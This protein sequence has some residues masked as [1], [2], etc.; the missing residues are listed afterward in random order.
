MEPAAR[1]K[2]MTHAALPRSKAF[3]LR[4]EVQARA[5]DERQRG[6]ID[7]RVRQRSTSVSLL[8]DTK[9][10]HT[11]YGFHVTVHLLKTRRGRPM[12]MYRGYT[13]TQ[14]A[15]LRSGYRRW[16]CSSQRHK[17]CK[18]VVWTTH[19]TMQLHKGCGVHTHGPPSFHVT[20]DVRL[21]ESRQG[22]PMVLY[23]GYS[24]TLSYSS[25]TNERRRWSCSSQRHRS[26]KATLW[27]AENLRPIKTINMHSHEPPSY[28]VTSDGKYIK[29]T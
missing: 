5:R 4:L 9:I 18:A 15:T 29:I 12:L 22:R 11:H 13:F 21:I 16:S 10:T 27:T 28:H 20:K 1:A 7:L 2:N 8:L 6:T 3:H 25:V 26:C 17:K 14:T 24:F 19:D 23:Q